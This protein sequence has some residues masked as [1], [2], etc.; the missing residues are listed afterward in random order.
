MHDCRTRD[1]R[2]AFFDKVSANFLF[3]NIPHHSLLLGLLELNLKI[4]A[5][6]PRFAALVPSNR[7]GPELVAVA[8]QLFLCQLPNPAGPV[9]AISGWVRQVRHL[10]GSADE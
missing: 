4:V 8:L 7:L 2:L 5:G 3:P 9:T 6:V 1:E 10:V